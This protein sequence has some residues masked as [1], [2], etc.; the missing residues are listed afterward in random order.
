MSN[1][2]TDS[3]R[4]FGLPEM[5]YEYTITRDRFGKVS[6]ESLTV[7]GMKEDYFFDN[8]ESARKRFLATP[9][10]NSLNPASPVDAVLANSTPPETCPACG[11]KK[12]G[13]YDNRTDPDKPNWRCKNK[14]CGE[15]VYIELPKSE[16]DE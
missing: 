9:S 11:Q 10:Y 8:L 4:T 5:P 15:R 1:Q 14:E 2:A 6:G 3:P 12:A 13:W 7:R 16:G